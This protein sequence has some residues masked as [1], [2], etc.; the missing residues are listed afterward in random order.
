MNNKEVL[1]R[2]L[3]DEI[4]Q[5]RQRNYQLKDDSAFVYWFLQAYLAESEESILKSL[6]GISKDKSIDAIFID[7]NAKQVN[8]IQGKFHQSLGAFT[9]KRNDVLSFARLSNLPWDT[10]EFLESFYLKLDPLAKQKVEQMIHCVRRKKYGMR[11]FYVT[12]GRYSPTIYKE[13]KQIVRYNVIPAEIFICGYTD[14]ITIFKDYIA[15]V[16]PAV[17]SLTLRISSDGSIQ[18]EGMV[19]R[20]DPIKE[21]ESYVFSMSAKDIGEMFTKVGSRL[22]ARNIRG[23][24]G[25]TEINDAMIDTVE[26]EPHNF[27]YYNN[28][29]TI[30]C[31]GAKRESQGRQ[32]VLIVDRPQVINGQ[33]TTRT[34]YEK[35]SNRASVLVKVIKIPRHP[36]DDDEY[37][38][39]V[40]SIVRATNWQNAIKPSDLVSNDCIQVFLEREFR[41]RGYQ[42][43]R[44][45]Q[46]KSEARR[47]FGSGGFY[48]IKKDEMAQAIA[49]CEFDPVLVRKGKENLFEERYYRSIFSSRSV[50]YYLSRYWLMRNVQSVAAG[51]PARAYAKWLVLNFAW[52]KLSKYIEYGQAEKRFRYICEY[53]LENTVAPLRRALETIFKAVLTFYRLEKGYGEMAKDVSTFFLLAKLDHEFEKFWRSNKNNYRYKAER[54]FDRFTQL[55]NKVE[56][57]E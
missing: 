15:G 53:K 8:I 16:A 36:G 26:H 6:T 37:D 24:L 45:R 39:L 1:F 49:A 41:K 56:I 18:T 48:Q 22:F 10:K 30:V 29:V 32:D 7:D 13:A 25:N 35:P 23:Y 12:T 38:D 3:K 43:I 4:N 46:S 21:I 40:S 20:Y 54:R 5:I 9:E 50:S 47:L 33:Q 31:D 52:K 19:H 14:I 11:L 44:K 27:W 51:Y 17:P 28:G 57:T 34:L 55:L 42:Y 2:E